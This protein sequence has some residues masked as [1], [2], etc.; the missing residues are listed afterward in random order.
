MNNS[1][2][3]INDVQEVVGL[4]PFVLFLTLLVS[5]V[6]MAIG[7]VVSIRLA[8]RAQ[9]RRWFR[10]GIIFPLTNP[11]L[12]PFLL[13]RGPKAATV[14]L[15]C[16][17]LSLMVLPFGGAISESIEVAHLRETVSLYDFPAQLALGSVDS[18]QPVLN[19][20]NV[21]AHPFMMPVSNLASMA[22]RGG[23]HG[24]KIQEEL[25]E[26]YGPLYVPRM[27]HEFP[28]DLV[29]LIEG[30]DKSQ[31]IGNSKELL[32][33]AAIVME[34]HEPVGDDERV[35]QS[36]E[37]CGRLLCD[38][39]ESS[40]LE[41]A[42]LEAAL[43][44][45]VDQYPFQYVSLIDMIV[46]FNI[47]QKEV[48]HAMSLRG[49]AWALV[50]SGDE[51]FRYLKNSMKWS[52]IGDSGLMAGYLLKVAKANMFLSSIEVVQQ[53]HVLTAEQWAVID[54]TIAAWEFPG[55]LEAILMAERRFNH[56]VFMKWL[57]HD[58]ESSPSMS[59]GEKLQ[60]FFLGAAKRSIAI[61]SWS[62]TFVAYDDVVEA[63]RAALEEKS[64]RASGG[65]AI[66]FK[67]PT[68]ST[69]VESLFFEVG[70]MWNAGTWLQ[71][72]IVRCRTAIALER[73]Y[74][75]KGEY[76]VAIGADSELFSAGLPIE[77]LTGMPLQYVRN[78][79]T[80]FNLG[81]PT[82][83]RRSGVID[84][85]WLEYR[86]LPAAPSFPSLKLPDASP[87]QRYRIN[88]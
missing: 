70:Q 43:G 31:F 22:D 40:S 72:R 9:A 73:H 65:G 20:S 76:P 47:W 19:E 57:S 81:A 55:D 11:F 66:A 41:T 61:R 7:Y 85:Q 71:S 18:P 48:G 67:S 6:L 84:Y 35:P 24:D 87:L 25:M 12:V 38:Y 60:S 69:E 74:L 62:K 14:A 3:H 16:Y 54:E 53:Y 36:W 5:L 37:K 13:R 86:I 30:M 56:F 42:S 2:W 33:S 27:K 77:P 75:R 49:P 83:S 79:L 52:M 51:A 68:D 15:G 39:F 17:L 10:F 82:G 59:L 34:R 28:S 88:E 4:L 8:Y 23:R 32:L 46:P 63:V 80:G 50:G 26:R 21:W 29:F 78:D 58:R 44:R 45:P 64:K 1:N